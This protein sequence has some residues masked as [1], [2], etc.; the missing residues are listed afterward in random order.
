[1]IVHIALPIALA[2]ACAG[3]AQLPQEVSRNAP[4]HRGDP[5]VTALQARVGDGFEVAR[6][7]RFVIAGDLDPETFQQFRAGTVRWAARQLAEQFF[8]ER[9]LDRDIRVFLFRDASSYRR[10]AWALF[11]DR[12]DTPYGYYSAHHDALVM[13][14]ATGGG[15]LVHEMVHPMLEA[16]FPAVPSWFNEGLASLFE[17]SSERD[18]KIVGLVNWRLAG[19]LEARRAGRLVPLSDLLTTTRAQFYGPRSGLHY[20]EARYL[21]LWLQEQDRLGDYYRA[22]R[23]GAAA[24]PTGAEALVALF[25]GSSLPEIE[26]RWLAWV[27]A[28]DR[29]P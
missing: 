21:L 24:D 22:F 16:D 6:E 12:P 11:R 18:G 17:Q 1:M 2:L 10:N 20:A 3:H 19:L 15:T 4:A 7:G 29:M 25:P 13:N 23:A 27:D 28:L 26:A 5:A 9:P 14:I 8:T